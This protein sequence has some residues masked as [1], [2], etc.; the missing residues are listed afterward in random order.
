MRKQLNKVKQLVTGK[1]PAPNKTP[2]LENPSIDAIWQQVK[3]Y[4][5]TSPLRVEALVKSVRYCVERDIPG[6]FV[7]CGVWKGGSVLAMIL[8]LQELGI[9]DRDI[10]LY[11]TYEGMTEPTEHDVAITDGESA[12]QSWR[13]AQANGARAWSEAFGEEIFQEKFVRRLLEKSN[14]PMERIHIVRGPVEKTIPEVAPEEIALL[15][16]DTDWYESTLHE[17]NEL[18]PR[19]KATGVLIID[20]YGHWKGCRKATD[21]YFSG[22]P[23][24]LNSIDYTG[25]I[26]I[27][28]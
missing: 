27:K 4:T 25:R 1:S 17:L 8:Q 11:D 26:A 23:I 21:E 20:D 3:P 2:S 16:L 12:L 7:E 9:Q 18:Y 10:Y 28:I 5:M 19:L 13:D 6:A 22:N 24:L 14:Y 15:R